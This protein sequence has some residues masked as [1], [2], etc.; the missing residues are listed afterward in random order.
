MRCKRKEKVY[1]IIWFQKYHVIKELGQGGTG[2]VF[3]A[4]NNVL[5]AER[6]IKR[7]PKQNACVQWM[8]EVQILKLIRHDNIP[9]VYDME[10]DENYIYIIEEYIKGQ[11]L[12]AYKLSHQ[13]IQETQ[14]YNFI[15][16]LCD[17]L[18][19]LHSMTPPI[20]YLDLKPDNV[21]IT[22]YGQIK[23]VDFG[24][25][26]IL[27]GEKKQSARYGTKSYA[28]P[29]QIRNGEVDE[30]SDIYGIGGM[31]HFMIYGC[32]YDRERPAALGY[33]HNSIAS[34]KLFK[35]MKK[36]LCFHPDQRYTSVKRIKKDL[37]E[38]KK[39]HSI[40]DMAISTP[41]IFTVAGSME[42]IG[43]TH[44][45][46][47]LVTYLNHLGIPSLYVEQN[48]RR[49]IETLRISKEM[50]QNL[51]MARGHIADV[52]ERY[53]NYHVYVC[54][55]GCMKEEN[56]D[57]EAGDRRFYVVGGKPWEQ[58]ERIPEADEIILVNFATLP[59]FLKQQKVYHLSKCYRIPYM[60][61]PFEMH[62]NPQVM[63]E[64]GNILHD[65][66]KKKQRRGN[67]K[68]NKVFE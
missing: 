63:K 44:I 56:M 5:K 17:V 62:E 9:I 61:E 1:T 66:S 18:E 47:M 55:C 10:E 34:R 39:C 29:E 51:D 50:T 41:H 36:C 19:F 67:P 43:T 3:L 20:L 65:F 7:I 42:R 38:L 46:F 35:I 53:P 48:E 15:L 59:Q 8:N 4:Y 37:E 40:R 16:Q 64:I 22:E 25:A 13:T 60:P 23:L 6:A 49:V 54:D 21:L 24:T 26:A 52:R 28:S 2:T 31:I 14:L 11:S 33:G 32:A 57:Y 30:R 68:K 45:C 58:T 12:R 27:S